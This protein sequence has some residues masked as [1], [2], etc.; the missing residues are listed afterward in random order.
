MKGSLSPEKTFG[1]C[2]LSG[3]HEFTSLAEIPPFRALPAPWVTSIT[4]L[5]SPPPT[6]IL[7]FSVSFPRHGAH[8]SITALASGFILASGIRLPHTP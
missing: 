4:A 7:I 8:F 6:L 2:L 3:K 1:N 5:T